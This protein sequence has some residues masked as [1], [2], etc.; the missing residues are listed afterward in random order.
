MTRD[1]KL[2][3][4]Q[5]L[6]T[7]RTYYFRAVDPHWEWCYATVNDATGELA[8][9]SDW[10]N[11]SYVWGT[12]HFGVPTLT[13]FLALRDGGKDWTDHDYVAN[14]LL[15]RNDAHCLDVDAT[16]KRWRKDLCERR[17]AYGRRLARL[18]KCLADREYMD[19]LY[20]AP[21]EMPMLTK[22]AARQLWEDIGNL[23]DDANH[24]PI[25]IEHACQIDGFCH[26]VSSEPWETTQ[27]GYSHIYQVLTRIILPAVAKAC[28]DTL[29]EKALASLEAQA[30][31]AS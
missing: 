19:P 20:E 23:A 21:S 9:T 16:I 31:T 28:H 5:T 26:W 30:V 8:I 6:T 4:R 7:A 29:Q 14:K 13:H 17:L 10:G 18:P 15:G 1:I 24:E 2:E 11:W 22:D 12:R 27:H 3:L 25:F